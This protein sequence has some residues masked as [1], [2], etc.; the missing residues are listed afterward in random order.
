[1]EHHQKLDISGNSVMNKNLIPLVN[2]LK[3]DF[4]RVHRFKENGENFG[5]LILGRG[6]SLFFQQGDKALICD[7]SAIHSELDKS[8][9]KIWD[10]GTKISSSQKQE[11]VSKIAELYQKFYEDELKTC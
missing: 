10:D 4:E 3:N 7:I 6:E 11:I 8:S 2:S 9:I 5:L 1:M